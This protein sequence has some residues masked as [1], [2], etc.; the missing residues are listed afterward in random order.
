MRVVVGK[1]D[2]DGENEKQAVEGKV[3]DALWN[4]VV[5]R[6]ED[7]VEEIVEESSSADA[8]RCRW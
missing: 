3:H 7:R 5:F 6:G 8:A 4:R 2:E 1:E